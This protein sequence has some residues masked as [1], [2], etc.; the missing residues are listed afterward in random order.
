MSPL[1]VFVSACGNH[2]KCMHQHE[3]NCL[4]ECISVHGSCACKRVMFHKLKASQKCH[5]PLEILCIIN[6]KE[7]RRTKSG[8][9]GRCDAAAL[10]VLSSY[11]S[12]SK[13]M[14][15]MLARKVLPRLGRHPCSIEMEKNKSGRRNHLPLRSSRC[16]WP[17]LVLLLVSMSFFVVSSALTLYSS[18]RYNISSRSSNIGLF[19]TRRLREAARCDIYKSFVRR[20][21]LDDA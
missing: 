14:M 6:T 21:S 18:A 2:M 20:T 15:M 5:S 9:V 19:V 17:R 16:N 8:G 7:T 13:L 4:D 12:D 10:C 11:E 3:H 1:S